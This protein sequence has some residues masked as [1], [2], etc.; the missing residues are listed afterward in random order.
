MLLPIMQN[1]IPKKLLGNKINDH[2]R[3]DDNGD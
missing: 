3:E 1:I 2:G